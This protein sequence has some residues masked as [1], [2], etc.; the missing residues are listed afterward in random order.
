[1][2][3]GFICC[4]DVS[5][6][7]LA[8]FISQSGVQVPEFVEESFHFYQE[9]FTAQAEGVFEILWWY[10]LHKAVRFA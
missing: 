5:G 8:T 2:S 4:S 6:E 7:Q 9:D 3:A 10:V 1:M